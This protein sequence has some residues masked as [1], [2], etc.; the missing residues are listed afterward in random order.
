[1][2][3]L[4]FVFPAR[5]RQGLL[6]MTNAAYP[7]VPPLSV[8]PKSPLVQVVVIR[9]F[10]NLHSKSFE[11]SNILKNWLR[12]WMDWAPDHVLGCWENST[13]CRY[14]VCSLQCSGS[15]SEAFETLWL[16]SLLAY[17]ELWP[18]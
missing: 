15:Y 3:E 2:P 17:G 9:G 12:T 10:W 7:L 8:W 1:L 4:N 18:K 5:L 13:E 6:K 16:I 11:F 14:L